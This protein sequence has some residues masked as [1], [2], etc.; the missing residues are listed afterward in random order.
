MIPFR[1]YEISI[2]MD[3]SQLELEPDERFYTSLAV[4]QN[5]EYINLRRFIDTLDDNF[6]ERPDGDDLFKVMEAIA[7]QRPNG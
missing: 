2:S 1:G 4:F 7:R 5:G 6:I 3:I